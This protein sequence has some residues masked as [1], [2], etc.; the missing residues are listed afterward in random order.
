MKRLDA[1]SLPSL[2]EALDDV[3]KTAVVWR[4]ASPEEGHQRLVFRTPGP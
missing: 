4:E 3:T 1:A 2:F